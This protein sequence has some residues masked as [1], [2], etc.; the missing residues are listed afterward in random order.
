V[1]INIVVEHGMAYKEKW[2]T[3]YGTMGTSSA[4]K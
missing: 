4:F 1:D 2:G 3:M